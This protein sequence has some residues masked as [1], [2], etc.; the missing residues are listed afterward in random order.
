MIGGKDFE[1]FVSGFISFIKQ[2]LWYTWRSMMEYHKTTLLICALISGI[3]IF[4]WYQSPMVYQATMV[5]GLRDLDK[6]NYGEMIHDLDKLIKNNSYASLSRYLNISIQDAQQLVDIEGKNTAG[7]MLYE[8]ITK[9]KAPV[10][11]EVTAR[12]NQI[13]PEV[14]KGLIN[15]LNTASRYLNTKAYTDSID[16][17][18]QLQYLYKNI[19]SSDSIIAADYQVLKKST[20]SGLPAITYTLDSALKFKN[21]L[22]AQIISEKQMSA[23]LKEPVVILHSFIPPDHPSGNRKQILRL[24]IL[25]AIVL[26]SGSAVICNALNSYKTIPSV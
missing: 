13:F 8:D 9:E 6:K 2:V 22:E 23:Q 15:Y 19:A 17:S 7:S 3:G 1:G 11:F 21:T 14:E 10:Y 5:A 26:S 12:N 4:L 18:T 25:A 24:T 20:T 16:I